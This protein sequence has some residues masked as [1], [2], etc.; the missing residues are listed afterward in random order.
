MK[1]SECKR[2]LETV[3]KEQERELKR[4]KRTLSNKEEELKELRSESK[5]S[6]EEDSEVMAQIVEESGCKRKLERV[7]KEQEEEIE[8]MKREIKRY[9][10]TL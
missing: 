6:M 2:N 5:V 4:Y 7:V 1:E 10:R 9:K 3:V 8:I